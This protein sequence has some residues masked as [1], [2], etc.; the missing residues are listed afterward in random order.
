VN[1]FDEVKKENQHKNLGIQAVAVALSIDSRE[2]AW[3]MNANREI[4]F[5]P[6]KNLTAQE[7]V[8]VHSALASVSPNLKLK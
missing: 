7:R 8:N 6:K 5:A 3:S 4:E 1:K 2:I